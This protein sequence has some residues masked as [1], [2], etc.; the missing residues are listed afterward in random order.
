ML[1]FRCSAP[2]WR[3]AVLLA[4]GLAL[5]GAGVAQAGKLS[6]LNADARNQNPQDMSGCSEGIIL[7]GVRSEGPG[8]IFK[9]APDNPLI[10]DYLKKRD[11][12]SAI[13]GKVSDAKRQRDD[14]QATVD[15]A[16]STIAESN[17]AIANLSRP[18]ADESDADRND[19]LARIA[20]HQ[21]KIAAAQQKLGQAQGPLAAAI[22]R[23][24]ELKKQ[25]DTAA[26]ATDQAR[27]LGEQ[28]ASACQ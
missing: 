22:A 10:V 7:L 23:Y 5:L 15:S 12:L 11:A 9:L 6:E 14:L 18:V 13:T 27:R 3:V 24:G 17:A 20:E 8:G 19:R 25:M 21:Q 4:A 16:E 26:G 1:S 2:S 28:A